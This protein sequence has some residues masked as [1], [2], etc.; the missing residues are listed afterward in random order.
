VSSGTGTQFT[1]PIGQQQEF[2]P[3]I[4]MPGQTQIL[5]GI[6]LISP[7]YL[8]QAPSTEVTLII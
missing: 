7:D 3:P 6:Q 8:T 4:F 1:G 5:P 2:I